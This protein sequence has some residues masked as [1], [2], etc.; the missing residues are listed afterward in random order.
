[1]T[2]LATTVLNQSLPVLLIG[3]TVVVSLAAWASRRLLSGMLLVP[4]RVTH[5]GE[6]HRLL[7]AAFIH[8][9]L[10]HLSLNVLGL[11]LFAP[12]P[13][14]VLGST[15]FLVLYFSAAVA[16]CIPTTLRFRNQPKYSSL[17]ASGA[18]AAVMFS[19][20]LLQLEQT[21]APFGIRALAMPAY[22]FGLGYLA[23]SAWHSYQNSGNINHDAHFYGA[24]YG[25]LYTYLLEPRLVERSIRHVAATL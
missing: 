16:S 25:A 20:I 8:A 24:A 7:T 11:Y 19:S 10:G 6:V 3:A 15:L 23:Y 17:G 12:A 13:L 22:V 14:K 21:I 5:R 1:M 4:Y 18:I 9:D 2:K